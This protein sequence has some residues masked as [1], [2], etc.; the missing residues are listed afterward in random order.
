M[1]IKGYYNFRKVI[2]ERVE[3]G[4]KKEIKKEIAEEIMEE[5]QYN[6]LQENDERKARDKI[7][8]RRDRAIKTYELFSE[9]G[10]ERIRNIKSNMTNLLLNLN[11][12]EMEY[13]EKKF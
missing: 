9:I 4:K 11:R 3:K 7:R 6:K 12:E 13:I 8:K 2:M 5:L 10:I 1:V